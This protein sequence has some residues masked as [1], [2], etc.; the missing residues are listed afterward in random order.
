M[1]H[2]R[3][4]R[5]RLKIVLLAYLILALI[6]S[7]AI[8]AGEAFC[9]DYSNND[10]ICSGRYFSSRSHIVDWLAGD[11]L[12]IRKTNG[13]SNSQSRNRLF[14]LFALAGTTAAAIYLAGADSKTIKND[15]IPIM[16]NLVLLKLRI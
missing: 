7:S 10:S 12:T 16:K 6:G 13:Y 15:N 1:V 5:K 3:A 4:E 14:R 2:S 8:S 9:F 11:V